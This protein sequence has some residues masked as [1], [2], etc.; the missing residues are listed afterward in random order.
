MSVTDGKDQDA[1]LGQRLF[2][3]GRV[4]AVEGS[5]QSPDYRMAGIQK[6]LEEGL[7]KWRLKTADYDAVGSATRL[8]PTK[9]L[10]LDRG[11]DDA[12]G[13]E[14]DLPAVEQGKVA[15]VVIEVI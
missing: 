15:R 12:R 1:P 7:F 13:K 14:G 8:G 2:N 3:V 4:T 9:E 6:Q 11:C 5:P 10:R